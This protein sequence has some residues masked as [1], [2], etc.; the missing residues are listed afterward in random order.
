[1]GY[2]LGY[3]SGSRGRGE[4][5]V[6]GSR[7]SAADGLGAAAESTTIPTARNGTGSRIALS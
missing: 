2:E 7:A 6:P 1:V 3:E 5:G 4:R